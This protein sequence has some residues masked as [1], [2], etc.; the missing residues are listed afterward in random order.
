MRVQQGQRFELTLSK[1]SLLLYG[2]L[3]MSLHLLRASASH[4]KS[5][6]I[7]PTAPLT[8]QLLCCNTSS[9]DM[10]SVYAVRRNR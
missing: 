7:A 8:L 6:Q 5:N 2:S 9:C 4:L 3:T 1:L 10:T